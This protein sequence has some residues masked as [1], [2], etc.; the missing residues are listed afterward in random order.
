MQQDT[1][2]CV[3]LYLCGMPRIAEMIV[4][5]LL[6]LCML[7]VFLLIILSLAVSQERVFFRQF[8]TGRDGRPFQLVK[9]STLRDAKPGVPEEA[10][11]RKRLTPGGRILRRLSLDELPQLWN[12]LIGDMALVGPRPLIH[13]YWPLYPDW[14]KARFRVRPGITGWAQINGRNAITFT[15]RFKLDCWYVEHRSLTMD[16]WILGLT[17]RTALSGK[18]VYQD[19]STTSAK[20]NGSN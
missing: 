13:E 9:F 7:P 4:V 18:G 17:L 16:L 12:V 8:R 19:S 6:M 14:A 5:L 1:Q 10:D 11:Q 2:P 15:E 3:L 20:F